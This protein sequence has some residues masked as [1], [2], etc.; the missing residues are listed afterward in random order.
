MTRSFLMFGRGCVSLSTNPDNPPAVR[1]KIGLTIAFSK[2]SKVYKIKVTA[3][4][5]AG[6]TLGWNHVLAG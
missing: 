3:R 2:Q 1:A 4:T 6:A 5:A